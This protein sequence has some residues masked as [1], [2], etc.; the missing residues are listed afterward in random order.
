MVY[1]IY[2]YGSTIL[3]KEAA[4]ITRDY[5]ELEK[6]LADL[7]ETMYE[8]DGVGL[9]APQ[10]G[11]SER[12][13]VVDASGF[14]DEE[15]ELA[16]FK[17]AFINAHIYER[18]GDEWI[19]NEGCLSLP[20]IR[21]DVSRPAKIKMRYMDE[22]FIEHDEE[23]DGM[24]ARIIQHEYDHLDGKLFIDH[25][26]PL[27]KTLIKSKLLTISKGNFKADYKCKLVKK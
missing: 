19:F 22:K 16:T 8:S 27:R 3:R 11:K 18:T 26:S 15:P 24:A 4:D 17:K 9:A 12:V 6:F 1:P 13:F 21:E 20:N 7:W 25:L 23:F 14:A 10:I 2:V 5:P